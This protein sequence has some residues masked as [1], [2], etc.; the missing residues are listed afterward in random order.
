MYALMFSH[1]EG[2]F[3]WDAME[4]S[5][6]RWKEQLKDIVEKINVLIGRTPF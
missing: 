4:M 5:H 3:R 2:D 1:S 6:S